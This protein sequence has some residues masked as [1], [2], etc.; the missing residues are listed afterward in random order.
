MLLFG[1]CPTRVDGVCFE[2]QT[3]NVEVVQWLVGTGGG[4]FDVVR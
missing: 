1:G 4:L 2:R 3:L